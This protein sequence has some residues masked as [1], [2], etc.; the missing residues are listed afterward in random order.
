MTANAPPVAEI[1]PASQFPQRHPH[2]LN[3]NRVQWAVRH[4]KRNGL[5]ACGAVFD[6]PCGQVMIHEPAFIAWF[7]GLAGRKKPRRA[8]AS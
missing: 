6:S 3:S 7:L 5:A 1:F 4:R 8:R 2:L